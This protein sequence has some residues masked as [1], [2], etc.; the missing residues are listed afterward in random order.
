MRFPYFVPNMAQR[1]NDKFLRQIAERLRDIRMELKITQ[2][3]V[4]EDIN[5][6]ISKIE[7]GSINLSIMT[8]AILCEYYGV[9]LEEFFK[10]IDT[11]DLIEWN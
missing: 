8:I 2:D 5:V 11:N 6:S 1:H 4:K 9:T 7:I 3:V 10:E